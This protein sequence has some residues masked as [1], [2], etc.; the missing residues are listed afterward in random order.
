MH[1]KNTDTT[2]FTNIYTRGNT[3][4]EQTSPSPY[5]HVRI[6]SKVNFLP[7]LY[8]FQQTQ[9]RLQRK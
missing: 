5:E 6:L 3:E 4:N 2:E 8:K 9:L 1:Y 7:K